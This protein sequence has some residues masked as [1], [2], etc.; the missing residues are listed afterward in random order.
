MSTDEYQKLIYEANNAAHNMQTFAAIYELA[1]WQAVS[2][3]CKEN[4][5]D[6]ESIAALALS[7][8]KRN[9]D[10]SNALLENFIS[11]KRSF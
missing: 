10:A 5:P 2:S 7:L 8:A 11:L 6:T 4:M 9:L 1:A 3:L